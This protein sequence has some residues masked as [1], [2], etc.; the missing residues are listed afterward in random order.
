MAG[1]R[2]EQPEAFSAQPLAV[3]SGVE[4]LKRTE[5]AI[6]ADA[7]TRDPAPAEG[8]ALAGVRAASLSNGLPS[9]SLG[10]VAAARASC[11]HHV[12]GAPTG[13]PSGAF[14]LCAASVQ[15]A[16]D[17]CLVAHRL[18]GKLGRP[19]L[20]RLAPALAGD[21]TLVRL[22]GRELIEGALSAE[23]GPAE[24]DASSERIL[25]LAGEAM[26]AVG[27]RTGRPADL[28]D[29]E[30]SPRSGLVLVGSGADAAG[31]REAARTLA[32]SGVEAGALSVNLLRPFPEARVREALSSARTVIVVEGQDRGG[33]LLAQ[34]RAAAAEKSEVHAL[35][36][37][38]GV[39]LPAAVA[40]HLPKGAFDREREA[41]AA[42]PLGRRLVVTPA[43]AWGEET[44]RLVASALGQLISLRLAP[45]TR[46][47]LGATIL[48]W[49]S[50]ALPE[51]DED[52][53]LASH[54][55]LLEPQGALALARD[56]AT[57]LVLSTAKSAEELAR[58]L[59][60]AT[61]AAVR[62]RELRIHWV[63]PPGLDEGD[64]EGEAE[65][66]ASFMLAGAA[67]GLLGVPA[68]P[69]DSPAAEGLAVGLEASG[70]SD[71]AYWVRAGAARLQ[72]LDSEDLE[73]GRYLEE[74][75]FRV[76]SKLPRMPVPV[77]DQEQRERWA[78][79]IARFHLT[80]EGA[81]S[82]ASGLP[83]RPAVL[84][85][86]A[87]SLRASSPQPFVVER[88]DALE[89]PLAARPL[90]EVLAEGGETLGAALV[91]A[92]LDRLTS[93]IAQRLNR[94]AA[95]ATLGT[96]ISDVAPRFV[97][98]LELS[99]EEAS[100]L[101]E[102]LDELR[103]L[104]PDGLTLDLRADTPLRLYRAVLE[105]VREPLRRRFVQE[106]ESLREGLRDL[107]ELDRMRSGEG[108][109]P[110]ALA[111]TLGKAAA[112]LL[113]PAAL[114]QALAGQAG[115]EALEPER[116]A[117][118][119]RALATLEAHFDER[120]E[121]P[122]VLFLRP[123]GLE[124]AL[125]NE[126]QREHPD[127]LGAAVG[128]FDGLARRMGALFQA[129]RLA[130]LEVAGRHPTDR[131]GGDATEL[132]WE[133]FTADELMLVP[134]VVAVTTGRHL[135]QSDRGSLSD[136]LRSSR[137][138]SVI[139]LDEVG[140][141]DEA[142]DLSR[143]H[144]DLGS[145]VVAH[146]EAYAFGSTL[147]RPDRAV[148]ALC[149]MARALRPAV[150]LVRLPTEQPPP[151]RGL[152]AEAALQGRACPDFRYD[153]DAG[154]SWADRFELEG[155]PQPE[156]PWPIHS[157]AFLEDGEEQTLEVP[158]TFAD[159]VALE[160]AYL[161]H[162]RIV[163]RA[164]WD[165]DQLPLAEYLERFDPEGGDRSIPY[166]WVLD[167]EGTLQRAVVSREL[168]L[169]CRDRL[170]SWQVL[171]ELAGY[172]NVFAERAA[173]RAK[174]EAKAEAEAQRAELE[175]AHA[176]EL[177]RVR[178]ETARESLEALAEALMQPGEVAL[179]PSAVTA[180]AAAAPEPAAVEISA[181]APVEAAA[182]V[183]EAPEEEEVLAFDEPFIDSPLC[184]TCNECTNI[185]SQLFK[186]NADKQAFIADAAAGTFGELVRAAELCPATCIHPGRPR[187]DD[188]TATPDML[189][190]AAKFN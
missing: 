133:A 32:A 22:P 106:L 124:V 121:L 156:R 78:R 168:A 140:A 84:Q 86:L 92:N 44:I 113:D 8:L 108:R 24:L 38:A 29:Y 177:E 96:L 128:V 6:C 144:I 111:A 176:E 83:V 34:V 115:A 70:Q 7:V 62:E 60:P 190:R 88:S 107:L 150:A 42:E 155:N 94:R 36:P 130:R 21:L 35:D 129:V 89:R 125:A 165:E 51:R 151:W 170:R 174:D 45:R 164:A 142:E 56:G 137:P 90:R 49:G 1:T 132:G 141:P 101:S 157:L 104:V 75:D 18:S 10:G 30:G 122:S 98:E 123:P 127:P 25:E 173:L 100:S 131:R 47:H 163:P 138:V 118:I 153:P 67:L 114:S 80:G 154:R 71:A 147:A 46:R 48:V 117:C 65:R 161:R 110:G 53:L 20:C 93:L 54:P 40:E 27:E 66:A 149:R 16:V 184:T 103:R 50:G 95:G 12:D 14:E 72:T 188:T 59:G 146:R 87:A 143:F 120:D 63:T 23:P 185:N 134:A 33:A 105:S 15:A 186:Y 76:A 119:E 179:P 74:V 167:E 136:L 2:P 178:S 109:A 41:P 159:A 99:D 17:H 145:L 5:R 77:E 68:E 158:C 9:S 160:P 55:A 11:V 31:A 39:P 166:I 4:A 169:A 13:G 152:L 43:G 189:E 37:A 183:E 162:L 171:Q 28:V 97:Q 26:R 102:Q 81:F 69:A 187:S 79:R 182:A 57:V 91:S 58:L 172:E 180:R 116:R 139:V 3:L 52:L 61:R 64:P 82:P 85:Q 175:Q 73:P 181:E 19:G 148:G 126:A 135:R 112:D